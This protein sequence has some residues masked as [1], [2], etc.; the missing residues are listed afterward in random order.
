MASFWYMS[1][2][3]LLGSNPASPA[4]ELLDAVEGV[5][6]AGESDAGSVR[7]GSD[8]QLWQSILGRGDPLV[9]GPVRDHCGRSP[10]S[11]PM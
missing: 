10:H 4:E 7:A 1:W 5:V 6:E 2:S 11:P 8:E 9:D 3:M